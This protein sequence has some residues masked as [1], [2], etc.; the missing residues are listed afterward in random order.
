[1]KKGGLFPEANNKETV[2][3]GIYHSDYGFTTIDVPARVAL[4][5]DDVSFDADPLFNE[6]LNQQR[7]S[8]KESKARRRFKTFAKWVLLALILAESYL[9]ITYF[10]PF[11]AYNSAFTL[12]VLGYTLGTIALMA[13]VLAAIAVV[14]L[15]ANAFVSWLM[16]SPLTDI[17][18]MDAAISLNDINLSR[19]T[20]TLMGK[21]VGHEFELFY[22]FLKGEN[23]SPEILAEIKESTAWARQLADALSSL[24]PI[25]I[26]NLMKGRGFR[27]RK[28]VG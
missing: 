23:V 19:P 9:A 4:K 25:S 26:S 3:A 14:C 24:P 10:F 7:P 6:P 16:K 11:L 28:D 21:T 2:P 5:K 15:L 8:N 18:D 12:T 13:L 20:P 17:D 1:M 27:D 22:N